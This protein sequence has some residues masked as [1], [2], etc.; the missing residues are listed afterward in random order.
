MPR[1]A[2]KRPAEDPPAGPSS[3]RQRPATRSTSR[4]ASTASASTRQSEA[5]DPESESEGDS[6]PPDRALPAAQ[7]R[8]AE[9]LEEVVKLMAR[10]VLDGTI[11]PSAE[12]DLISRLVGECRL[13]GAYVTG[14]GL[15][16]VDGIVDLDQNPNN[17]VNP[18]ALVQSHVDDLKKIILDPTLMRD[19]ETP[20]VLMVSSKHI[21]PS[22]LA[23]IKACDPK[24]PGGKV[25]PLKLVGPNQAKLEALELACAYSRENGQLLDGT[26]IA[27]RRKQLEQL[28]SSRPKATLINGNHRIK[29]IKDIGEQATR[30]FH[31]LAR[32]L[33]AKEI[34]FET[35]EQDVRSIAQTANAARYRV[36]VYDADLMQEELS[37]YLARNDESRIARGMEP[38][39]KTWWVCTRF[40]TWVKKAQDNSSEPDA[41]SYDAAHQ[42]WLKSL[43][44]HDEKER[45]RGGRR[46]EWAGPDAVDRLLTE[47]LT[48]RMVTDTFHAK[49]VYDT[50][51]KPTLASALVHEDNAVVTCQVW[52]AT[53]LLLKI[54][55][56][57]EGIGFERAEAYLKAS[58]PLTQSGDPASVAHWERIH[59]RPEKRP[60]LLANYTPAVQK[61][62]DV[63]YEAEMAALRA[64]EGEVY[65]AGDEGLALP[66][67]RVFDGLGVWLSGQAPLAENRRIATS[68][69]MYARLP[70]DDPRTPMPQGDSDRPAP[71]G[72]VDLPAFYSSSALPAPRWI[73]A[74]LERRPKENLDAAFLILDFVIHPTLPVWT[75]GAQS[76]GTSCNSSRWYERSRGY[77]NLAVALMSSNHAVCRERTLDLIIYTVSASDFQG[78]LQAIQDNC[79]RRVKQLLA[80][81]SVT[82]SSP[83]HIPVLATIAAEQ[84]EVFGSASEL[85]QELTKARQSLQTLLQT[86]PFP[87]PDV[88]SA[89]MEEF[90]ALD[91][92]FPEDF[93]TDFAVQ[94]WL[95]GWN[96]SP[97]RKYQ[98][99]NSLV[100][101]A[102][103]IGRLR[104]VVRELLVT[105]KEARPILRARQAVSAANNEY[106]TSSI[107]E[108]PADQESVSERAPSPSQPA[109]PP[110]SE[111]PDATNVQDATNAPEVE[112][113]E[114][115]RSP[116]PPAPEAEGPAVPASRPPQ[117]V[118]LGQDGN[119][120]P[121]ALPPIPG[122]QEP[123]LDGAL[124][125]PSQ[126]I[127]RA[128]DPTRPTSPEASPVHSNSGGHAVPEGDTRTTRSP[129]PSPSSR[130]S[131][132]PPPTDSGSVSSPAAAEEP[133]SPLQPEPPCGESGTGDLEQ[134]DAPPVARPADLG[135]NP[136]SP[137]IGIRP[138]T[139][140]SVFSAASQTAVSSGR[141]LDPPSPV[142]APHR[143]DSNSS[144][145]TR[146]PSELPPRQTSV[147][148]T[149][150]ATAPAGEP[151]EQMDVEPTG[152]STQESPRQPRWP[153]FSKAAA[154]ASD[155]DGALDEEQPPAVDMPAARES[156]V[157]Q[158]RS[159]PDWQPAGGDEVLGGAQ[160][161]GEPVRLLLSQ[162]RQEFCAALQ[163]ALAHFQGTTYGR[164]LAEKHVKAMTVEYE[165]MYVERLIA[166]LQHAGGMTLESA[167]AAV[168]RYVDEDPLVRIGSAEVHRLSFHPR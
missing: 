18:R 29:A 54:Y 65:P 94:D 153:R 131:L 75:V 165:A 166:I 123:D 160:P 115:P 95:E 42:E 40:L 146:E 21:E 93:W 79:G 124:Q 4:T 39:E 70:L 15:G 22:C 17:R 62:F 25:P 51:I 27:S 67:R 104:L 58:P 45:K 84:P 2:S 151:D 78:A 44:Q 128:A 91:G 59:A 103:L 38:S 137:P 144:R 23:E 73:A 122:P 129:V 1:K 133:R 155:Q 111:V 24:S 143:I 119:P 6:R 92:I 85:Q 69:R 3:K 142:S 96:T 83:A 140:G 139:P 14:F 37:G 157:Q 118:V 41:S 120:I 107:F 132:P 113:P 28:R 147:S 105:C 50:V 162:E 30:L 13:G 156:L 87:S 150:A 138:P 125:P 47:P 163:N 159:G 167:V 26:A 135:G 126:G 35:A 90:S 56:V 31:E 74:A 57:A 117:Y 76:Q 99:V 148:P 86:R 43:G 16:H 149:S 110:A 158:L 53:R 49:P 102:I 5:P 168:G 52:L 154:D 101:W 161:A 88:I 109:S 116:T 12:S 112:S 20:I 114:R 19:W 32:K 72:S 80:D 89:H 121:F 152:Q 136:E 7:Q 82:R 106:D 34:S 71:F 60:S 108:M 127:E 11:E 141:G 145:P 64:A 63:L 9:Q 48:M 66:L 130:S 55:D 61:R 77:A 46:A 134:T 33:R 81:C 100:G 68:L 98:D 10:E 97:S 36:E 164:A 8:N